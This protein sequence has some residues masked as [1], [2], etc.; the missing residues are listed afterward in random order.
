MQRC[1]ACA[2]GIA[3]ASDPSRDMLRTGSRLAHSAYIKP[4]FATRRTASTVTPAPVGTYA[5]RALY[6]AAFA[7]GGAVF[8]V[9][10]LDARSAIHRYLL[11]P[12]LRHV[13]DAE[14]GHKI[15]VQ[16]LRAGLGPHDPLPDDPVLRTEVRLHI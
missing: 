7:T 15:A 12:V 4:R 14:T 1:C 5:R 11:T 3:F 2:W 10:Y 9:Y 16:V 6:A 8:S 13:F